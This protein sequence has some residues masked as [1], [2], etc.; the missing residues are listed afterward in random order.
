MNVLGTW[1]AYLVEAAGLATHDEVAHEDILC[2]LR[3]SIET[4]RATPRAAVGDIRAQ[5]QVHVAGAWDRKMSDF[6][7][8]STS[9]CAVR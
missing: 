9:M 4:P 8:T 1:L 6:R 3:E 7:I 5:M 2:A